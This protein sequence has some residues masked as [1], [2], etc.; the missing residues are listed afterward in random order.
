MEI[1]WSILKDSTLS[2]SSV[3]DMF[4]LV[5]C[6]SNRISVPNYSCIFVMV[7]FLR[8]WI[9]KY[10]RFH[11]NI[12]DMK[13]CRAGGLMRWPTNTSSSKHFWEFY[14]SM[15]Y[16]ISYEKKSFEKF[17][18]PRVNIYKIS[19]FFFCRNYCFRFCF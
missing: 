4:F 18:M 8:K 6:R 2:C 3:S 11:K 10:Q 15:Q 9:L 13:V 1:Y 17:M 19:F 16:C 14:D 5:A 7:F 12:S